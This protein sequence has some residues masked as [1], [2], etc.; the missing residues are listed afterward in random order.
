MEYLRL[1]LERIEG[2]HPAYAEQDLL[3]QAVL[4]PAAVEA[5]RDFSQFIAVLVD[6]GV[7]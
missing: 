2:A 5:V 6:V 4:G 7:E 1:F 3:A